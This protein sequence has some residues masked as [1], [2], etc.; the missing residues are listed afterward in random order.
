MADAD[1]QDQLDSFRED[2]QR[3]LY[4]EQKIDDAHNK[5]ALFRI[6]ADVEAI[7]DEPDAHA[8]CHR[9]G[10]FEGFYDEMWPLRDRIVTR[11]ALYNGGYDEALRE[12][13]DAVKEL[14]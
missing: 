7:M 8:L 11:V 14:A 1:Y 4:H 5:D 6:Y 13:K 12:V 2:L 10:D 9:R 3:K